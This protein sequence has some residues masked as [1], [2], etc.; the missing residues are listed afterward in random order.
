MAENK[1]IVVADSCCDVPQNLAERYNIRILPV[2]V[3]YPE[4]DYL[5]NEVDPLMIYERF[6]DEIPKTSVPSPQ[7]TEDF[8]T[9]IRDE[10]YTHVIAVCL[11]D[12]LSG[13]FNM[14]SMITAELE[15]L[16]TFV[17][18]TKDISIGA[19]IYAIWAARQVM[20]G[21]SFEQITKGLE[22]KREDSHLMFYMDTLSY[23]RKGGRIGG[24]AAMAATVLHLK[25]IIACDPEGIYY[26]VAKIR[27]A[28]KGREH[29]L[30]LVAEAAAGKRCWVAVMNG[31]AR[32]ESARMLEMV[33]ERMPQAEIIITEHQ[34]NSSLA[35]HTGPGLIGLCAFVEP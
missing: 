17:Y 29:L 35:V 14:V 31:D 32:E 1:I 19:G 3:I 24:V 15:G 20:D 26:T 9:A 8:F 6:P 2:H 11:S 12:H 13:T 33:R 18:N 5:D 21:I 10:G 4:K 7:E 25:P 28:K 34:I 30:N 16:T 27:G 23:L 22:D